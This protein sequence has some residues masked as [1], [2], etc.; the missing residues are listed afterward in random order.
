MCVRSVYLSCYMRPGSI[1]AAFLHDQ[2]SS[3]K[4]CGTLPSQCPFSCSQYSQESPEEGKKERERKKWEEKGKRERK[5]KN[6]NKGKTEESVYSH[7]G[8]GP[9]SSPFAATGSSTPLPPP[10]TA[11]AQAARSLTT[12]NYLLP[13][14]RFICTLLEL[15]RPIAHLQNTHQSHVVPTCR[16]R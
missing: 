14:D 2:L 5:G 1:M 7:G 15:L 4:P 3:A 12:W 11:S 10:S 9:P 8:L 6:P 16:S 13:V